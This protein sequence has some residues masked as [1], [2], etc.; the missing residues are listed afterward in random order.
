MMLVVLLFRDTD[1][2]EQ[3]VALII[4]AGAEEKGVRGSRLPTISKSQS[5]QSINHQRLLVC[6][7]E[8]SFEL[9]TLIKGHDRPAAEISYK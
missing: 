8:Q 3:T 1:A 2:S 7:F 4:W 9:G 6:A 5:P